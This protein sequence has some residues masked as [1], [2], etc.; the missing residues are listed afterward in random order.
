MKTNRFLSL[1]TAIITLAVSVS[2]AFAASDEAEAVTGTISACRADEIYI[3]EDFAGD[4]IP[5]GATA[6]GLGTWKTSNAEHKDGKVF[7]QNNQKGYIQFQTTTPLTDKNKK[8]ILSFD[9]CKHARMAN[10]TSYGF[11]INGGKGLFFQTVSETTYAVR[12]GGAGT[13]STIAQVNYGDF[14]NIEMVLTIGEAILN[15]DIMVRN[16][17]GR[18]LGSVKDLPILGYNADI[19]G[20]DTI[21]WG[22]VGDDTTVDNIKFYPYMDA[23]VAE[24]TITE[25]TVEGTPAMAEGASL[26]IDENFDSFP[27]SVEDLTYTGADLSIWRFEGMVVTGETK[28]LT[29]GRKVFKLSDNAG[30]LTAVSPVSKLSYDEASTDGN[31]YVLRFGMRPVF[32]ADMMWDDSKLAA[33]KDKNQ[34]KVDIISATP[35]GVMT[36]GDEEF[37]LSDKWYSVAVTYELKENAID[38]I[39]AL[40]DGEITKSFNRVTIPEVNSI[41][42]FIW[43]ISDF[44]VMYLD[45]V[46]LYKA[47]YIKPVKPEARN[48]TVSGVCYSGRELEGDYEYFDSNQEKRGT[49]EYF[50]VRS[51]KAEPQEGEYEKIPGTEQSKKYTLT[52]DDIGK[53]VFFAVIPKKDASCEEAIGDITYKM[54]DAKIEEE[55]AVADLQWLIAENLGVA[56]LSDVT[57]DL[58]LKLKGENGS[59]IVW[60]S[61]DEDT[62]GTDGTVR[63]QSSLRNVTLTAT[64][65]SPD[66]LVTKE[67]KFEVSVKA[68]KT[69][70]GGS[71]GSGGGG[72]GA[73]NVIKG[74]S[75]VISMPVEMMAEDTNKPME[76]PKHKYN[77]VADT[78]WAMDYIQ[79]LYHREIATGDENNNFAPDR[80]IK[81][82]EFTKMIVSAFNLIDDTAF[83]E[84]EDVDS[85]AWYYSYVASAY[86]SLLV[87]GVGNDK[88]G[89]GENI[90]RQD[91]AVIAYRILKAKGIAINGEIAEEFADYGEVAPYAKEAVSA[92][93]TAGIMSGS[94]N[95][96]F[97]PTAYATR[98]EV[99]RIIVALLEVTEK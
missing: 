45:N 9:M 89:I 58:I 64:I 63:R 93:Q 18:K 98:A 3:N 69:S 36:V 90:T 81:R 95:N 21:L 74:S 24:P 49:D 17:N 33:I 96:E 52:S 97:R 86:K 26:L 20:F 88:F 7:M 94:G 2:P 65:T 84:F 14:F 99:A 83:V 68:K 4:S 46:S 34:K 79:E 16:A 5:N 29:S 12:A 91:M 28:I 87:S 42:E 66:K 53:Y 25:V 15:A 47:A 61:D 39:V 59:T 41:D 40:T 8:Y 13:N 62:I 51:D 76:R 60:Q 67:H 44:G 37:T 54:A 35:Q 56:D 72:G 50:W 85:S 27:E 57:E 75:S 30:L 71:G 77:D 43:S 73:S 11:S 22:Y 82:E 48:M 31:K 55:P 92:M 80:T 10:G 19:G 1:I 23:R 78:H 38:V 70:Q 32:D 6:N